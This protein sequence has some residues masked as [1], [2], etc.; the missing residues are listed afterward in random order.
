LDRVSRRHF[1]RLEGDPHDEES[2]ERTA[3]RIRGLGLFGRVNVDATPIS[4]TQTVITTSVEERNTGSL[5]V[6]LT[7]AKQSGVGYTLSLTER[8]LLGRGQ[9]I[10]VSISAGDDERSYSLHFV[11]PYLLDRD[12]EFGFN[13]GSDEIENFAGFAD[14]N[15]SDLGSYLAF[16]ISERGRLTADIGYTRQKSK[17]LPQRVVDESRLIDW[18]FPKPNNKREFVSIGLS[19]SHDTISSGVYTDRGF[20]FG[21]SQRLSFS[22]RTTVAKTQA[23]V[24]GQTVRGK[25]T[26]Q[27]RL[28]GGF[29]ASTGNRSTHIFDRFHSNTSIIRGFESYGIGPR[30][31]YHQLPLGGNRFVSLQLEALH[32]IVEG[33]INVSGALFTDAAT[34]WG[35]DDT[36]DCNNVEEIPNKNYCSNRTDSMKGQGVD[37]GSKI[38][39]T[40]GVGLI[41]GTPIGPMRFDFSKAF[42]KYAGDRTQS[43]SLTFGS[44]F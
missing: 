7:Y 11:E 29:V 34:I 19:Y 39:A 8:N 25:A 21:I 30:T 6:G 17:R 5:G 22:D 18:Q 15:E 26:L 10:G 9:T 2:L 20:R 27:A 42:R 33:D 44:S 23:S 13:I 43:F 16:P 37:D 40:T 31:G 4:A 14:F 35:L 28:R 24:T 38:R 32:P 36:N 41:V 3:D 12:L 1:D